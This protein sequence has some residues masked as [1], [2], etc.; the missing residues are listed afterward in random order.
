M[1]C[2]KGRKSDA[3]PARFLMACPAGHLDEFPWHWFVHQGPSTCTGTLRFFE[4]GASLQTENLWVK[5]DKCDLSRSLVHAFGEK[6][7]MSLPGCRGR[8]PHLASCDEE[9]CTEE[10][11]TILLGATN[12]WFSSMLS[13]LSVPEAGASQ[14][15][16]LVKDGWTHFED[17]DSEAA[18]GVVRKTLVKLNALPGLE[19]LSVADLWK[20]IVAIRAENEGGDE[21]K[22]DQ[23][24]DIK[25][26]EWEA[27]T[28]SPPTRTA[29]FQPHPTG[30]PPGLAKL[31]QDVVLLERLR[32]VNALIGFTRVESPD[33]SAQDQ[34]ENRRAP[35]CRGKPEWIPATAVH[36][37]GIFIRFPEAAI[38][39]WEALPAVQKRDQMLLAGH[40]GWRTRRKL[41]PAL[42]YPGIRYAMLHT[43][44][45]LLIRELAL[46][47]GYNAS[48]IRERIYATGQ[49]TVAMAGILLYT[50][51]PDADGT[52]GGL[53]DLGKPS[54]LKQL[55]RSALVRASIC[56]SDPL[57]SEHKPGEDQSCHNA[58]C[59]ACSFVAETSCERGNRYL[60]RALLIPTFECVDAGY[61]RQSVNGHG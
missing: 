52:L 8:H 58:S 40:R 42:G 22:N 10:P 21:E 60:D 3:V 30:T 29:E 23:S 43:V 36:G 57:C 31:I 20:E 51:A 38:A 47:C 34:A 6:A 11:R 12:G 19:S 2:A 27:L 45:H 56:S 37:E 48:S 25:G 16:K 32:E 59:H 28:M 61:F 7:R 35:L 33:D 44:S 1:N 41:D 14:A 49:G 9:E 54:N 26:P 15:T 17:C 39:A 50:A 24:G 53:V 13:M 18:A 46:S 5:C 4:R 55:I